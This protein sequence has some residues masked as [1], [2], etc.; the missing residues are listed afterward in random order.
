[1]Q[2]KQVEVHLYAALL[3]FLTKKSV[4]FNT[5]KTKNLNIEDLPVGN[6]NVTFFV[7]R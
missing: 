2:E 7:Q 5:P 1:M 3:N 6:L 4:N